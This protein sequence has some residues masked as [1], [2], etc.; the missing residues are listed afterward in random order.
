M[1]K[2][3]KATVRLGAATASKMSITPD[4]AEPIDPTVPAMSISAN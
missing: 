1:S 2:K 3:M 4:M